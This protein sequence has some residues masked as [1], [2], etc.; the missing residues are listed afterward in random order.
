MKLLGIVEEIQRAFGGGKAP[1][2]SKFNDRDYLFQKIDEYSALAIA[3]NYN[4]GKIPN[5]DTVFKGNQH[6]GAKTWMKFPL[7]LN[8]SIQDAGACYVNFDCPEM[9]MINSEKSG[10]S[11]VGDQLTMTQFSEMLDPTA[12]ASL[13]RVKNIEG[14]YFNQVGD[15]LRVIGDRDV[16]Q[17]YVIGRPIKPT[18]LAVT[19]YNPLT[20]EYPLP[21]DL[22][23][24]MIQIMKSREFQQE[25]ATPQ[26][27]IADNNPN[28]AR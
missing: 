25:A 10:F 2:D 9:I 23:P 27:N 7:T 16:N 14:I 22:I 4:G 24:M 28:M 11:F 21:D 20:D 26:D 5:S 18:Q 17:A 13:T 1:A 12:F 6:I 3:L 8:P 15:I 19:Y